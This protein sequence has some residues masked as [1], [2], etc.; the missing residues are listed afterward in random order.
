[1][2]RMRMRDHGSVHRPP[3][4]DVEIASRTVQAGVG[5]LQQRGFAQAHETIIGGGSESEMSRGGDLVRRELPE[6]RPH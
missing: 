5:C 6:A 2:I 4:V 3:G 1:M